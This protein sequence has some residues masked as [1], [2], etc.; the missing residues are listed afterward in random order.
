MQEFLWLYSRYTFHVQIFVMSIHLMYFCTFPFF[1]DDTDIFC[2]I[3]AGLQVLIA[4]ALFDHVYVAC[5]NG[6]QGISMV[7]RSRPA[8]FLNRKSVRSH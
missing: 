7:Q 8:V 4:A 2:L 5:N 1:E 3:L 6:L